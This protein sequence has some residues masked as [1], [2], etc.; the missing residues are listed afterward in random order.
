MG[1]GNWHRFGRWQLS[2]MTTESIIKAFAMGKLLKVAAAEVA[3]AFGC[4]CVSLLFL[5][6]V[7]VLGVCHV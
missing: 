2:I 6:L 3:A 1:G 7:L 5:V 4:G